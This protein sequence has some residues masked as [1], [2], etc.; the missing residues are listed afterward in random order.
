MWTEP[1]LYKEETKSLGKKLNLDGFCDFSVWVENCK[2]EYFLPNR[3]SYHLKPNDQ[4]QEKLCKK[5]SVLQEKFLSILLKKY[6][7]RHNICIKS[8]NMNCY[9]IR[10]SQFRWKTE[11]RAGWEETFLCNLKSLK[12]N[13]LI[14]SVKVFYGQVVIVLS[15]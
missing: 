11:W 4:L 15:S 8:E 9:L 3:N 12:Y 6:K 5:Y 14:S 7:K 2:W 1:F 13:L 10:K